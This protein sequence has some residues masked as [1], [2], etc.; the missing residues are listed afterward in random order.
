MPMKSVTFRSIVAWPLA[1]VMAIAVLSSGVATAR[2][3]CVVSLSQPTS[4]GMLVYGQAMAYHPG[5]DRIL[6]YGGRYEHR[7]GSLDYREASLNSTWAWNGTRW[8][9]IASS[10]PISGDGPVMAYDHARQ[11]MILVGHVAGTF[12]WNG[13]SWDRLLTDDTLPP[14]RYAAIAFDDSRQAVLVF[15]GTHPE[16]S[17]LALGDLWQWNGSAWTQLIIPG[18]PPATFSPRMAFDRARNCMVVISGREHWELQGTTWTRRSD[19]PLSAQPF[20]AGVFY[21]PDLQSV[22][23]ASVGV[24]NTLRFNGTAWVGEPR[25]TPPWGAWLTGAALDERRG[26]ILTVG[27]KC[28]SYC[29]VS[30]VAE[31]SVPGVPGVLEHPRSVSGCA[32]GD[33]LLTVRAH[34]VSAPTFQWRK[35]TDTGWIDVVDGPK[36]S[37]AMIFGATTS[38][39]RVYRVSPAEAGEYVCVITGTCGSRTTRLATISVCTADFTCDGTVDF[40]DYLTFV[41]L[42]SAEHAEA[43]INRNGTVDFFDYLDFIAAYEQGCP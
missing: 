1:L 23:L 9:Q 14:R 40:F 36:P 28:G 3:Q 2:A 39:I 43:D 5:E 17:N 33:V 8:I 30:E 20:V 32:S 38:V 42:F 15:G 26:S 18:G 22:V 41:D 34:L 10:G 21:D 16:N 24:L 29:T 12:A 25:T 6:L 27:G 13:L 31:L 19:V 11:Q 37:G 7:F 4:P 35:R